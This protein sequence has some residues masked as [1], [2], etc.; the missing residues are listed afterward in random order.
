MSLFASATAIFAEPNGDPKDMAHDN[1]QQVKEIFADAL[2][3]T[4]EA[5][6]QFLNSVCSEDKILRGE[7]ESLLASLESAES[8][9]ESPAIGD[10]AA[11]RDLTENRKFSKGQMLGHYEI[12]GQIGTG[13]MGD[14][15]LAND[16]KLH[17]RVALKILR[18]NLSPKSQAQQRLWREARAVA[19]LDHP[20]ICAIYEISE[21]GEVSF[22]VQN[23]R[24]FV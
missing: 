10:Y 23:L 21:A 20:N 7:V 9:M 19:K 15:Y 6:R 4:P 5:R 13:G 12:V 22:I 2:R 18:E 1:W 24:G 14:V 16:S 17:R 3:H 11:D 8:F